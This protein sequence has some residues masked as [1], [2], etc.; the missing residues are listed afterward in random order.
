MNITLPSLTDLHWPQ[1]LPRLTST[2]LT[3]QN[4]L[5]YWQGQPF[6]GYLYQIVS[7]RHVE[8]FYVEQGIVIAPYFPELLASC[9]A[10]YGLQ[11]SCA[12]DLTGFSFS[13]FLGHTEY[14]TINMPYYLHGMTYNGHQQL[15][16][17]DQ[18]FTGMT[19]DTFHSQHA[20]K[21]FSEQIW[22]NGEIIAEQKWRA[23]AKLISISLEKT[24]Q[25]DFCQS[26]FYATNVDGTDTM[27]IYFREKCNDHVFSLLFF[28]KNGITKAMSIN[29]ETSKNNFLKNNFVCL[30][31]LNIF[32]YPFNEVLILGGIEIDSVFL[33]KALHSN[34]FDSVIDM[35]INKIY[36]SKEFFNQL[37]KIPRLKELSFYIKNTEERQHWTSYFHSIRP[38]VAVNA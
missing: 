17:D 12:I 13:D 24:D 16:V 14:G 28:N 27:R 29:M 20:G 30:D 9:C 3:Q 31:N 38:D 11:I 37:A 5:W 36:F 19:I 33:E 8:G 23:D 10:A 21:V 26:I 18:L 7:Q 4:G 22:L 34:C 1:D 15:F 2:V 25:Y 35:S 6:T 32:N